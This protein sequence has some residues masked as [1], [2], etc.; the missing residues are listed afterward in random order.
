MPNGE[1]DRTKVLGGAKAPGPAGTGGPLDAARGPQG[2]Q[3][4]PRVAQGPPALDPPK[5]ALAYKVFSFFEG[6]V[7]VLVCLMPHPTPTKKTLKAIR[8]K[9]GK[10]NQIGYTLAA[11]ATS[12]IKETKVAGQSWFTAIAKLSAS[13]VVVPSDLWV[14]DAKIRGEKDAYEA[15]RMRAY[16]AAYED[17]LLHE[18]KH[19]TEAYEWLSDVSLGYHSAWGTYGK[20]LPDLKSF[21]EVALAADDKASA[22]LGPIKESAKAWDDKD[23][24]DMRG[25]QREIYITI[26]TGM[27]PKIHYH[28][29]RNP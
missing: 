11:L 12:E 24:P 17:I 18:Q 5:G 16:R 14:E 10:E 25:R 8:E 1:K 26:D 28:P 21:R 3:V 4:G 6:Q 9:T 20:T 29:P 15:G 22:E 27:N 7:R 2:L 23:L 13:E 19:M